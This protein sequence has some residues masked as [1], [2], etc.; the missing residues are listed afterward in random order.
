MA[1]GPAED[2][3]DV[4]DTACC[5]IGGGP[6]G[7]ML[8]LLLARRGVLVT[9]L[10]AHPTFDRDFRGVTIHPGLLEL[11][12]DIGLAVRL[13]RLPHAKMYGGAR[14]FAGPAPLSAFPA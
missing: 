14:P 6:G 4:H 10:E 9:L 11:L 5:V 1:A 13:P 12:D 3:R 2:V 8:A 7:V